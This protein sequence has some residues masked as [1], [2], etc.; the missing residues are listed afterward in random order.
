MGRPKFDQAIADTF[1]VAAR[2]GANDEVCALHAGVDPLVAIDWA[3]GGTKAK[4]EFAAALR[5][6][7]ADLQLLAV[8]VI[9]RSVTDDVGAARY[10][11]DTMAGELELQR[12]RELTT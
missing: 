11:A 12:L 9:R 5:K 1:L 6:A 10:L 8:G 2:A 4:D 3:R 7:R